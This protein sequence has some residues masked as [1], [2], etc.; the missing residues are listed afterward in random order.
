MK[1]IE[2]VNSNNEVVTW[3][4]NFTSM[5][6]AKKGLAYVKKNFSKNAKIVEA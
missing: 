2:F 1:T 3:G 6:A 4:L 5:S